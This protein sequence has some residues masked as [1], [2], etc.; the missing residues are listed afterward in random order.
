[1]A[2]PNEQQLLPNSSSLLE[3]KK[4]CHFALLSEEYT[5]NEKAR[6]SMVLSKH[7]NKFRRLRFLFCIY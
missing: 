6:I 2:K 4:N 7:T 5:E 1:M 3:E